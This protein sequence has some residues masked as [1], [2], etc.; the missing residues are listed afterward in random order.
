MK[1]PSSGHHLLTL[2]VRHDGIPLLTIIDTGS[3]L[4]LIQKEVAKKAIRLPIDLTQPVTMKDA[5]G[6]SSM[7]K[8]Y[9][10]EVNL[11][12]GSVSTICDL[13]V[14]D[15]LPFDLILGTK[16]LELQEMLGTTIISARNLSQRL[17]PPLPMENYS[18][19]SKLGATIILQL[20]EKYKKE[21]EK[22]NRDK[23]GKMPPITQARDTEIL[24]FLS[25][26]EIETLLL[27]EIDNA[28]NDA[29]LDII[30]FLQLAIEDATQENP[31]RPP[32]NPDPNYI[33]AQ[34]FHHYFSAYQDNMEGD[35]SLLQI[36]NNQIVEFILDEYEKYPI[37]E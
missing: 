34:I 4:N 23:W 21:W 35:L 37:P 22:F 33:N 30:L 28:F 25:E 13:H 32:P 10:P 15:D 29:S 7:L 16:R 5:N 12:C 17:D 26:Q 6:G 8:G 11:T 36:P 18:P 31:I 27:E 9:L 1:T 24:S 3:E 19:L 14:G 2:Q 20:L